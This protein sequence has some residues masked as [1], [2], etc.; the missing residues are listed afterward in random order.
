MNIL[1]YTAVTMV[2]LL[3]SKNVGGF[4]VDLPKAAHFSA[5]VY[6]LFHV[7]HFWELI[8]IVMFAVTCHFV[9]TQLCCH[10]TWNSY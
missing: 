2:I 6:L 8:H 10:K 9:C 4:G 3:L 1:L 7:N 5:H